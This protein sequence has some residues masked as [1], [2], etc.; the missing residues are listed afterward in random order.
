MQVDEIELK[1]D[2][3]IEMYMMDRRTGQA[4]AEAEAAPIGGGG[5]GAEQ[6]DWRRVARSEAEV[7]PA[8][9]SRSAGPEA[10]EG[11][12]EGHVARSGCLRR[13]KSDS[14]D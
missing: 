8:R 13:A 10:A 2:H 14:V 5:A 6:A 12:A 4:G 1:L 3:L 7:A 9:Q 11:Q